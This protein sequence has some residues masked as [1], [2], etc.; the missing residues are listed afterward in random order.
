MGNRVENEVV[1]V[2]NKDRFIDCLGNRT[3]KKF[4][5]DLCEEWGLNIVYSTFISMINNNNN[6]ML[7]YALAVS[8][9][10]DRPVDYLFSLQGVSTDDDSDF[11]L[12]QNLNEFCLSDLC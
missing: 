8:K 2:L 9:S 1:A 7:T 3:I 4:Y 10:L 5:E 11:F 6:W 12:D